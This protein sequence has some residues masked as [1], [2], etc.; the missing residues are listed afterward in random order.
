MRSCALRTAALAA[1]LWLA[2]CAATDLLEPLP[3]GPGTAHTPTGQALTPQAAKDAVTLGRSTQAEV[4]AALGPAI[5]IPFDNGYAVWV[6][7]W[8]GSDRTPAAATE[9]VLLF[10]PDGRAKK[11]RLR[12][13]H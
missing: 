5:A 11:A 9:L 12:P 8:P 4:A 10:G 7:R 1:G 3:Q 13:G 2:G 6:Y